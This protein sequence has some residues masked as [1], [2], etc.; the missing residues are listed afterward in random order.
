MSRGSIRRC[1]TALVT[2]F[3]DDGSVDEAALRG[4]V[5]W[6]IEQGI[7]FLVPCGSTGEAATL[8]DDE[9]ARVVAIAVDEAD[10]AVPVVAGAGA[11]D[12]RRAIALTRL[13][14]EAGATH[15]LHA[16]PAYNKPPQRGLHAHF[17]AVADAAT[18]PVVLYNVPGRTACDLAAETTLAL[19]EHDNV[20]AIKEASG[21]PGRV[22]ELVR[23]RPEGF[24]VLSGDDAL[25]LPFMALGAEGVI[26]VVGN[27]VPGAMARL[28]E[29]LASG[30]LETG[31]R[32]HDALLPLM[33]AMFVESNPI[34]VKAA[35]AHRD[36]IR[37]VLRLPL[38]PIAEPHRKT[39]V[40]A[41][42]GTRLEPA[43]SEAA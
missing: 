14:E 42:E 30:D 8:S 35:L 3:Q 24:A 2:P 4:L 18:R 36:R 15:T 25:T 39:V 20:I 19:A 16:A 17:R 43:G 37:N 27:V 13:V 29:S 9:R 12:T 22:G 11:S 10:G 41:L 23:R 21:D 7:D 6:Q 33:D 31:Q 34:P 26:S 32:L 28:V 5:R 1:G 40:A 38:V